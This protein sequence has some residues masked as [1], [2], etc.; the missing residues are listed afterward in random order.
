MNSFSEIHWLDYPKVF[1]QRIKDEINSLTKPQVLNL[2][3]E[4]YIQYLLDKYQVEP[5]EILHDTE[6][7]GQPVK[8]QIR[9]T[10][11]FG[12]D[13]FRDTFEF[14]VTYHF[15]G[16]P[17]LFRVKPNPWI[18]KSYP[19]IVNAVNSTVSFNFTVF[20]Q[21]VDEFKRNKTQAYSDAF[22]NL[23]GLNKNLP[24]LTYGLDGNIRSLV[25]Q[26]KSKYSA[27]D[28]FFKAVGVKKMDETSASF[29]TPTIKKK[30]II[31]PKITDKN[32]HIS[33]EPS[34]TQEVYDDVIK[35][36]YEY[37]KGME[38]K[39]ALYTAKDE[40]ALRDHFVLILETRYEN[41]TASG[42]TFNRI[43]K[44]D[45]ILKYASDAS[46]LF[47]AECKFWHGAGEFHKAIS[48]LLGYLTWRD[49]KVALMLFVQNQNFSNVLNTILEETVKHPFYKKQVR[50]RGESSFSYIF[51]LPL[52]K[53]KEIQFEIMAFHFV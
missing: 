25:K 9:H 39:P 16:T 46:N 42:E 33:S 51:C 41:A 4:E 38:K 17:E 43:G 36:L 6:S 22:T 32:K 37:G 34:M 13:S 47:V 10:G 40:E 14:T 28:D 20:N 50:K 1:F 7:V 48:Q 19:I 26:L 53:D 49:S 44:T 31:Q 5:L 2:N 35:T 30:V 18:M 8:R 45:I 24:E 27:E 29:N 3:E 21:N 12:R 11:N 23:P 52:D 15:T